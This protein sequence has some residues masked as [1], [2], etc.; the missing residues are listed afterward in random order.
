MHRKLQWRCMRRVAKSTCDRHEL[1]RATADA[2][3]VAVAIFMTPRKCACNHFQCL[4]FWGLRF[5]RVF[6]GGGE[7]RDAPQVTVATFVTH[8]ECTCMAA[9]G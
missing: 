4:S 9:V 3:Q 5:G 7:G 6:F 1:M 2:S 8:L